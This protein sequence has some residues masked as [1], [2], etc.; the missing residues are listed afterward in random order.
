MAT[1]SDSVIA[2]LVAAAEGILGRFGLKAIEE[3][4]RLA[5]PWYNNFIFK[6]NLAQPAFPTAFPPQPGTVPPPASGVTTIVLRFSNPDARGVNNANRV[7]NIIA[8]Q[9]LVCEAL[10]ASALPA[11]VPA[12]YAWAPP[13]PE[14]DGAA[15]LGWILDEFRPGEDLH[16]VFSGLSLDDKKSVVS[17]VANIFA[18]V[19][20][21]KLPSGVTKFGALTFDEYGNIV[22]GQMPILPGGPWDTYADVWR[23]NLLTELKNSG[24]EDTVMEGWRPNGVRDRIEEFLAAAGVE[25]ILQD[26]DTSLRVLVHGDFSTQNMLF[27]KESNRITALLDFDFACVTHPCHEFFSGMHD[28][29]GGGVPAENELLQRA[30]LS[31]VFEPLSSNLPQEKM[32]AW[33]LAKTWDNALVSKGLI[34]PSQITGMEGLQDLSDLASLLC[35]RMLSH[36]MFLK[37]TPKEVQETKRAE[38]EVKI[39][40]MLEK[41]T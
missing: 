20:G 39:L 5:F 24:Q 15:G 30:L 36:P 31:G 26:V 13:R 37:R 21:A 17:Q 25:R 34:R 16:E 1:T 41:W 28:E 14:I 3:P 12:V 33:E 7:Q 32:E 19:Q 29:L 6:I 8:S 11:V 38:T 27:D 22:D 10:L 18:C 9:Q 23:I 35:P 4:I 40:K 2:D